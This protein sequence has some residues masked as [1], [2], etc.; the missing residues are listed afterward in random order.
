MLFLSPLNAFASRHSSSSFGRSMYY[1]H[2]DN[3]D[4]AFTFKDNLMTNHKCLFFHRNPRNISTFGY[5]NK[6]TFSKGRS[7]VNT[8]QSS[9]LLDDKTVP[10]WCCATLISNVNWESIWHVFHVKHA[11]I[12]KCTINKIYLHNRWDITY[13]NCLNYFCQSWPY[14]FVQMWMNDGIDTICT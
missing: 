5:F 13:T 10:T 3:G 11:Q 14:Y 8:F 6:I 2:I 7:H 9:T 1:L 4:Y 12:A